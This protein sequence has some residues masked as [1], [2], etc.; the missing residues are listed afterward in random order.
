MQSR[1]IFISGGF[2]EY[3]E[4]LCDVERYDSIS[5]TWENLPSLNLSRS[6]HSSCTLGKALY[7]LGGFDDNALMRFHFERLDNINEPAPTS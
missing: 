5:D 3:G 2:T 7:V 6:G 4:V 1:F